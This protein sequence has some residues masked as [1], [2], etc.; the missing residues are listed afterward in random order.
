MDIQYVC[1]L[2]VSSSSDLYLAVMSGI[3]WIKNNLAVASKFPF[4]F[5]RSF[6]FIYRIIYSFS[7]M[8]CNCG[9]T[10]WSNCVYVMYRDLRWMQEITAFT[11]RMNCKGSGWLP[12]LAHI[13]DTSR[14]PWSVD[15]CLA[16][17]KSSRRRQFHTRITL[18][19][20]SAIWKNSTFIVL[21]RFATQ[22]EKTRWR[23]VTENKTLTFIYMY[24]SVW[25]RWGK[26]NVWN[27]APSVMAIFLT[28]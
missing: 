17:S 3:K 10:S 9:E 1:F 18:L 20:C 23:P 8:K 5:T 22:R 27:Q 14:S 26:I 11:A 19:A 13:A 12:L 6:L 28:N 16:R 7:L 4:D 25:N 24:P 21:S 2:T 15:V